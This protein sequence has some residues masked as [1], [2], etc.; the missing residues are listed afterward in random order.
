MI[1]KMDYNCSSLDCSSLNNDLMYLEL[2]DKFLK[3]ENY[4]LDILKLMD[5]LT[6]IIDFMVTTYITNNG[7]QTRINND[8]I[9]IFVIILIILLY[10]FSFI[11]QKR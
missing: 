4:N 7:I 9:I 5:K 2:Y 8:I 6:N 1:Y 3:L 11:K 10:L